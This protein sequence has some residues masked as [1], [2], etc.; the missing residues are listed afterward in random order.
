VVLARGGGVR[1]SAKT[2][3]KGNARLIIRARNA[4][5]I[6]ITVV[7]ASTC[8]SVSGL[9]LASAVAKAHK[10]DFTG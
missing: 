10:A 5:A 7:Q 1:V 9:V 8:S 4:G 6:R 2:N 3:G